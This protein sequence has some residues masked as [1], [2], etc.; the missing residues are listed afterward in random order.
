MSVSLLGAPLRFPETLAVDR[1]I[2]LDA[3]HV[4]ALRFREVNVKEAFTIMDAEG[5][6]FR[7]SLKA[8]DA[9]SGEA[10][11]YERMQTS[12]ESPAHISLFCAVLAR[13]RMLGVIQKATELGVM[14]VVPVLSERSVPK[15]GLAHE[16]AHAWPGQALRAAKQCR[17]A[18]IPDIQQAIPL[19]SALDSTSFCEAARRFYL[20][21]RAAAVAL[22]T[23][24]HNGALRI[25]F[26]VGPEGGF[27]DDE[28]QLLAARGAVPLRVGGRVL[29]A[30]TSALVGLA[31]L[32]HLYGDMG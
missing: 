18:S 17:R 21:D 3:A 19:R 31:L 26:V 23:A 1:R 30:E 12:P 29:R 9:Q 11:V 4:A 5:N 14:A 15:S 32:Q 24:E 27:T 2:T 22:P 25:A 7:A 10:I 13:Q 8:T 16:K 28:R 20:D 6:F